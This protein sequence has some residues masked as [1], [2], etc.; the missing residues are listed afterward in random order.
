MAVSEFALITLPEAKSFLGIT[1]DE[2]TRDMWLTQE[3]ERVSQRVETWLDRRVKAR[4]YREDLDDDYRTNTLYLKNTPIVAVQNVYI[5]GDRTFGSDTRVED[6]EYKVY[7]DRIEF[8][9]ANNY[10]GYGYEYYYTRHTTERLKTIRVEYIAGWGTLEIP[11]TRQRIDLR[12]ETGGDLLTFYLDA[13]V[14]SPTNIVDALNIELNTDGDNEREVSFD[15]RTRTFKITQSDGEL[16][17]YPSE[18]GSHAESDSALPLLGFTGTGH[19]SSPATGDS[20]TLEIPKDLKSVVLDL[21]AH[22]YDQSEIG[23]KRR[24]IERYQLDDYQVEYTAAETPMD[25]FVGSQQQ[26]TAIAEVLSLY[27][28]WVFV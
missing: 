22:R 14:Q 6:T 10:Y 5:D 16:S 21:I 7:G 9:Y 25:L 18:S 19:D 2:T 28:N 20:R 13:G 12:G 8:A 11:F 15:W 24:G 26:A 17:L 1:S 23:N 27:K 4:F 3:V